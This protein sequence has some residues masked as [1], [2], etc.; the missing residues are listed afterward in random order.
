MEMRLYR[1]GSAPWQR[2]ARRTPTT[3]ANAVN[4][5]DTLRLDA[6]MDF[7]PPLV[8]V[9]PDGGEVVLRRD[10]RHAGQGL[11][12]LY[13]LEMTPRLTF[14]RGDCRGKPAAPKA[15]PSLRTGEL[16]PDKQQVAR[17]GQARDPAGGVR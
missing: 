2:W 17:P 7:R 1:S 4:H 10:L 15:L 16:I 8:V 11:D 5:G 6:I 12:R 9:A 14:V 13:I 3:Q